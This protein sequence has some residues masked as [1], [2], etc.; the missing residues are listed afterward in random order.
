MVLEQRA[1][2]VS[3]GTP[4]LGQRAL[5]VLQQ[6][7]SR[8]FILVTE[9]SPA[10]VLV[11]EQACLYWIRVLHACY[12]S[13]KSL[14]SVSIIQPGPAHLPVAGEALLLDQASLCKLQSTSSWLFCLAQLVCLL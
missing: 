12:S 11:P 5:C 6:P 14:L 8:Q 7:P 13:I 10:R 3:M 1:E 9:P 4:V 2:S